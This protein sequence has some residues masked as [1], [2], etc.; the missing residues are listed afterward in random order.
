MAPGTSLK[1]SQA[2]AR[3]PF[4]EATCRNTPRSSLHRATSNA[5]LPDGASKSP[6]S[7]ACRKE[8][9]SDETSTSSSSSSESTVNCRSARKVSR[10]RL[11]S[12]TKPANHAI[13]AWSAASLASRCFMALAPW[14]SVLLIVLLTPCSVTPSR[15][16]FPGSWKSISSKKALRWRSSRRSMLYDFAQHIGAG[17]CHARTS[18]GNC[19]NQGPWKGNMASSGSRRLQPTSIKQGSKLGEWTPYFRRH[20]SRVSTSKRGAKSC[21]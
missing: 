7:C 13:V 6:S 20:V 18:Y 10:A 5:L 4:R 16:T 14:R 1:T 17:C 8:L 11:V 2:L 15:S 12:F 9:P 3:V 21:L 19:E